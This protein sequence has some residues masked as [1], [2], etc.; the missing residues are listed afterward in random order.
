MASARPAVCAVCRPS[1]TTRKASAATSWPT[2]GGVATWPN[3]ESTNRAKGMIARPKNCSS[4]PVQMKGTRRQ[5]KA[6]RWVSDRKPVSA[7][8][9]ATNSGSATMAATS[10]AGT[11][12]STIITRLSVPTIRAEAMPKGT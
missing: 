1:P 12:S 10:H 9:G 8:M 6:E 4:V 2:I 7:R 3:P 5:P 11:P